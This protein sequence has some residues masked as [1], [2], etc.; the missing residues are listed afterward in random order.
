MRC[1]HN[2]TSTS[3]WTGADCLTEANKHLTH[4]D[5]L[6][7]S[8]FSTIFQPSAT[9]AT[10]KD[11]SLNLDPALDA[12]W[13]VTGIQLASALRT[14]GGNPGSLVTWKR[15]GNNLFTIH[16]CFARDWDREN[17]GDTVKAAIKEWR[18]KI[19]Q[20][21]PRSDHGPAMKEVVDKDG[22]SSYCMNST[23]EDKW[24]NNVPYDTLPIIY[25]GGTQG[26][27]SATVALI[28]T[29]SPRHWNMRLSTD[30]LHLLAKTMHELR[31]VFSMVHEHQR[32]DR[33]KYIQV[34]YKNLP[35]CEHC[36]QKAKIQQ[37]DITGDVMC[38]SYRKAKQNGCGCDAYIE[39]TNASGLKIEAGSKEIDYKSIMMYSS[40]HA[41]KK[42]CVNK[43]DNCPLAR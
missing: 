22:N 11:A 31:H 8:A 42:D 20:A 34:L 41:A 24:K 1:D 33:D 27:C 25:T 35:D 40:F 15:D 30:G 36:Y 21:S 12:G 37:K 16:Y 18:K 3:T 9:R 23:A 17:I 2:Y 6:F 4:E 32:A 14:S 38:L 39:G 10:T 43:F 28:R 5:L 13:D 19:G 26:E 7:D 29:E